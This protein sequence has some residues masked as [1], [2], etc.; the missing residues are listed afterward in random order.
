M[1]RARPGFTGYGQGCLIVAETRMLSLTNTMEPKELRFAESGMTL[2]NFML[3]RSR[4]A[5][6]TT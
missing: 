6:E 3:G 5:I 4:A 2:K 1:V